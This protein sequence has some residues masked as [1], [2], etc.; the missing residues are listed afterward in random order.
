MEHGPD[1]GSHGHVILPLRVDAIALLGSHRADAVVSTWGGSIGFNM[2][3][4]FMQ[5]MFNAILYG[6]IPELYPAQCRT[7]ASGIASTLGR[8]VC[9]RFAPLTVSDCQ[10]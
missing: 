4:Y 2:L 9:D 8:C 1:R 3:E 10:A 7:S 6:T 5:S